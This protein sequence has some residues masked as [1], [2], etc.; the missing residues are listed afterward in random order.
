MGLLLCLN[1]KVTLIQFVDSIKSL[2]LKYILGYYIFYIS[3][4]RSII[5]LLKM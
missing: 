5:F 1:Q 3:T 4:F 2:H